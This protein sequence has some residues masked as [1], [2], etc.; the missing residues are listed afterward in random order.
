MKSDPDIEPIAEHS[1]FKKIVSNTT[2]IR[3]I[4]NKTQQNAKPK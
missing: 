4:A 3:E 1:K 2:E